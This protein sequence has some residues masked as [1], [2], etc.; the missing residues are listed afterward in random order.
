M[1]FG[2]SRKL[3]FPDIFE[4]VL[5]K[6]ML[7]SIGIWLENDLIYSKK[8]LVLNLPH[9]WVKK[10]GKFEIIFL[11]DQM[12]SFFALV[13]DLILKHQ[14]F[15]RCTQLLVFYDDEHRPIC[16]TL[17]WKTCSI[18]ENPWGIPKEPESSSKFFVSSFSGVILTIFK[19]METGNV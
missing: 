8:K 1:R 19:K 14:R 18:S 15:V 3:K 9:F 10:R 4:I 2:L 16:G 6:K 17:D 12:S 11:F 7:H 5:P 13:T